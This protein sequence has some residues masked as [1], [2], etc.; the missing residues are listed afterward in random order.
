MIRIDGT[1]Y[2]TIELLQLNDVGSEP[3]Y[4]RLQAM[5]KELAFPRIERVRELRRQGW[6]LVIDRRPGAMPAVITDRH[7][8]L[9][10]VYRP[11]APEDAERMP[12][13]LS[14]SDVRANALR[15]ARQIYER[16]SGDFQWPLDCYELGREIGLA[17]KQNVDQAV[18]YLHGR[19]LL[20]NWTQ[21]GLVTLSRAGIDEV[22]R[23]LAEPGRATTN[24]PPINI[25]NAQTINMG[26]G[27]QL[28]QGRDHLQQSSQVAMSIPE[29][30]QALDAI[31][32]LARDLA[33][34]DR[35]QVEGLVA[36]L[37]AEANRPAP[38]RS[39]IRALL[40]SLKAVA[41]AFVAGA[42]AN[43]AT[44][45]AIVEQVHQLLSHWPG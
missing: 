23:A 15:L 6:D 35:Q 38:N 11:A 39:T 10:L 37:R 20:A 31:E 2:D 25:I 12:S 9:V 28:M 5:G 30:K 16:S 34:I 43:I 22:E 13:V 1:D 21:G 45:P 27:A 19:G 24:F 33:E 7:R 18:A 44:A 32:K 36:A 26:P 17:D 41:E 42:A 14:T 3:I 8:E 4:Q 29:L 40:G